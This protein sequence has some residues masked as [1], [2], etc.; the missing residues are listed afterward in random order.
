MSDGGDFFDPHRLNKLWER[1]EEDEFE[2]RERAE[3]DTEE[4]DPAAEA[5]ELYE[6]IVL[7]CRRNLGNEV[8]PLI[9]VLDRGREL[10][11]MK[12][13]L[14]RKAAEPP[15]DPAPAPEEPAKAEEATKTD[16]PAEEGEPM[17]ETETENRRAL[18]GEAVQD[19]VG[20]QLLGIFEKAKVYSGIDMAPEKLAAVP[21]ELGAALDM[22]E[23]LYGALEAGK[24]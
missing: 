4:R 20:T 23:D 21:G 13:A 10:L 8:R 15:K 2:A 14:D 5:L 24:A 16:K 11:A 22:I 17:S 18:S 19:N 6:E 9:A 3:G 12:I 7:S 1:P